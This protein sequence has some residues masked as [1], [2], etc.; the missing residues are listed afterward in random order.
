MAAPDLDAFFNPTRI[1]LVGASGRPGSVGAVLTRNILSSGFGGEIMLVNIKGGDLAGHVVHRAVAELPRAPDLAIVATPAASVPGLVRDLGARGCRAAVIISAGFEGD[2]ETAR[3]LRGELR[4]AAQIAGVRLVGPNCL[5]VLAPAR[6]LNASF[7]RVAA[8]AGSIALVS[9]SGAVAA[10]ALD[11]APPHG[12]GFSRVVTLGDALDVDAADLLQSLADDPATRS[13]LLYIEGVADGRKFMAAARRAALS[14]PVFCLKGGRTRGG[15]TAAFSHTRA[16]AGADDVYAAA[17]RRAGVLQVETLQALLDLALLS[18]GPRPAHGEALAILTNGG[19][20]GVLAVDALERAGG[21]L[22]GLGEA[23][24]RVLR[25]VGPAHGACG[26]PVDILG[27]AGPDRYRRSLGVLLAAPEV[28]AVLAIN[29][30]TAVAD[31]AEAATAILEAAA[32][33]GGKTVLAAW[34]GEPSVAEGRRR[35]VAGGAPSFPT[36]EAAV[37]A[38]AGQ[39]K[40]GRLRDLASEAP[41]ASPAPAPS[42]ARAALA[43][44]IEGRRRALAP[45][46]TQALLRAYGLNSL[47]AEFAADPRVAGDLALGFGPGAPVALKIQSPDL[48]HKTDVGGVVLGLK[49]RPAT[50]RAAERML[51]RLAVTHP[52]ARI[53]GFMVQPLVVRP[54]AHEVLAGLFR[55]PVFGPVVVVGQGGVAVEAAADRVL[56]LAP[57][58]RALALDMI[59]RTR[60]ARYLAGYRDRPPADLAALADVLVA[61]SRLALDNPEVEELDLNPVLCDETGAL[62][63]DARVALGPSPAAQASAD[64]AGAP[65]STALDR[66][67]SAA[68]PRRVDWA[69]SD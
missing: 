17:L 46:E 59:G 30:P 58:D 40:A 54:K 12:L 28:E 37:A 11:W 48:P 68:A 23:T 33:A 2:D 21:R 24:Q 25:A 20:A 39:A 43:G 7:A 8:P 34:L 19:G 51:A 44:A 5:G 66:D 60:V 10:A 3:R 53:E 45:R 35:L 4:Q 55:D 15:A 22:A 32:P 13:I 36:V 29:C 67:Q 42:A 41:L 62:V 18:G 50:V 14:K 16:L 69:T 27:D 47:A 64:P 57:L 61:L 38:F 56:G 9:Q 63:L 1:A 49:G 65:P 26:N 52:Q 31:S 6:G